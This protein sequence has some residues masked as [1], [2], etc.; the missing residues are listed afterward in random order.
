MRNSNYNRLPRELGM[1]SNLRKMIA[2]F[3][4]GGFCSGLITGALIYYAPFVLWFGPGL[5]FGVGLSASLLVASARRLIT[6][7]ASLRQQSISV[8]IVTIG[9][10]M[11]ILIMVAVSNLYITLYRL[12][13]PSAWQ[14]HLANGQIIAIGDEGFKVGLYLAGVAAAIMV[15]VA[16]WI[17]T[18]SWD[19][20]VFTLLAISSFATVFLF[21]NFP[22]PIMNYIDNVS[23]LFIFGGTLF[24]GL[25]GYWLTRDEA[26]RN[27]GE[28][29]ASECV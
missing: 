17:L 28:N 1:T 15:S 9:Y 24:T 4:I 21:Y 6:L 11:S 2:L 8:L 22:G 7:R 23:V 27:K 16:L 14:Q 13:F 26:R 19:G 10:P 18:R 20:K 29:L 25:C 3:L 12:L 5:I